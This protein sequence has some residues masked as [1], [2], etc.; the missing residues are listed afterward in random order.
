M[1]ESGCRLALGV[2]WRPSWSGRA[3]SCRGVRACTCDA[4]GG[5]A[6]LRVQRPYRPLP[7]LL[8]R[9][10]PVLAGTRCSGTSVRAVDRLSGGRR[11]LGVVSAWCAAVVR[12]V[13]ISRAPPRCAGGAV[14]SSL[15]A[16]ASTQQPPALEE[17]VHLRA[18]RSASSG[19]GRWRWRC[20]SHK[21]GAWG[22]WYIAI[23]K[24]VPRRH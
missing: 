3:G 15:T 10:V 12:R 18:L 9:Y 20:R 16:A 22:L 17:G 14:R 4:R 19:A 8:C 6:T 2:C 24:Q 5:T 1:E 21:R 23:S 7:A 13:P 11:Y